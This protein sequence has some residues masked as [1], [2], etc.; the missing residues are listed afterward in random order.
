MANL[1]NLQK[2]EFEQVP[3]HQAAQ[4]LSSGGYDIESGV[5]N[6][7]GE[8]GQAF[9]VDSGDV[10]QSLNDGNRFETP[11]ETDIRKYRDE[12]SGIKGDLKQVGQSFGNQFSL[13]ALEAGQDALQS[14]EDKA[15]RAA[16]AEDHPF[17][18]AFGGVGGFAASMGVGTGELG[19][20]KG[21][22]ELGAKGAEHLIPAAL[23]Q[24]EQ[25]LAK[26]LAKKA[27]I[28]GVEGAALAAPSVITEASLGDPREAAEHLM[29]NVGFG[30]AL[31]TA[32]P[33][34]KAIPGF[35]K[36]VTASK[37]V[38]DFISNEAN[39]FLQSSGAKWAGAT[40]ATYKD[41]G[42]DG[43]HDA[44]APINS[45]LDKK[46]GS[47]IQDI[48]EHLESNQQ[49]LENKVST[50][51]KAADSSELVNI[52]SDS[53]LDVKKIISDTKIKYLSDNSPLNAETSNLKQIE[54][55]LNQLAK[56][57]GI[58]DSITP[59][60]SSF[61]S[62]EKTRQFNTELGKIGY[63]FSG[64][65]NYYREAMRD[66]RS[67]LRTG[68]VNTLENLSSQSPELAKLSDTFNPLMKEY[69]ANINA[70][71]MID[72][73]IS[74]SA[75][76]SVGLGGYLSS[77]VGG[78]VGGPVGAVAG[79]AAKKLGDRFGYQTLY[80][81]AKTKK[82]VSSA[83]KDGADVLAKNKS[84][85]E[86]SLKNVK[87]AGLIDLAN[88]ISGNDE[89]KSLAD[90]YFTVNDALNQSSDSSHLMDGVTHL[91]KN[92]NNDQTKDIAQAYAISLGNALGHLKS[93]MPQ[94][95]TPISGFPQDNKGKNRSRP[96]DMQLKDLDK[97]VGALINPLQSI[98]NIS[99]G[100]GHSG[101]QDTLKTVYPM[102]YNNYTGSISN[103]VMNSN[104]SFNPTSK[105]N[106]NKAIGYN[107][108]NQNNNTSLFQN[109]Y[110][111]RL[112]S[113]RSP[114]MPKMKMENSISNRMGG[115]ESIL[116]RSK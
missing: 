76:S 110:S 114:G 84:F 86:S 93:V 97:R 17:S 45:F 13:G 8:D 35:N 23:N 85:S 6:M 115:T 105:N 90:A 33:L 103:N 47:S 10:L 25:T 60:E 61:L 94:V 48:A 29:M 112:S 111:S 40:K 116:K 1:Y 64:K 19:L 31:N 56:K 36:L 52:S 14:P 104:K 38:N 95:S 98:K 37:S 2:K 91:S 24:G 66:V 59:T 30:G 5:H 18:A 80:Q 43:V 20:G 109:V 54:D 77:A 101:E 16:L 108:S 46:P 99:T 42:A 22:L 9:G 49:L 107:I 68:I 34:A 83:I 3:D 65:D 87:T 15:K 32:L 63:D 71:E 89:H 79:F 7:V 73:A 70:T 72:N 106:I 11:K 102:L 81:L 44:L 74:K 62:L 28:G 67:K 58:T 82:I 21:L 26:T 92:F 88:H 96:S 78:M 12:N 41:I 55:K 100:N 4:A 113:E 50:L 57:S 53:N 39:E 75:N 27:I 51:L 69:V